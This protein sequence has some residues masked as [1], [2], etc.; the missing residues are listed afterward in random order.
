[1]FNKHANE[2]YS[3]YS[4]KHRNA[5]ECVDYMKE[6]M[7]VPYA[8]FADK[9]FNW[10]HSHSHSFD[11]GSEIH[12][13][14]SYMYYIPVYISCINCELMIC[15]KLR[16]I[17]IRYLKL[18]INEIDQESAHLHAIQAVSKLC[19]HSLQRP[20][21]AKYIFT[22]PTTQLLI[23]QFITDCCTK[24]LILNENVFPLY[25][26]ARQNFFR[27][28]QAL[29]KNSKIWP[30]SWG[31]TLKQ[32]IDK[33]SISIMYPIKIF[34]EYLFE[35]MCKSVFAKG[36][37]DNL[38]VSDE[39]RMKCHLGK[40]LMLYSLI[41]KNELNPFYFHSKWA[42]EDT[43]LVSYFRDDVE[44][45]NKANTGP[46]QMI[47]MLKTHFEFLKSGMKSYH[48]ACQWTQ[49]NVQKKD[50]KDN[51]NCV[52]KKCSR[53]QLARYCTRRCQKMDWNY[54]QHKSI[55]SLNPT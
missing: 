25:G 39:N 31:N 40:S 1:M 13:L 45:I 43:Y 14:R 36:N 35:D 33:F 46:Q 5:T 16:D 34:A 4:P 48:I 52:W 19:Q 21:M 49:C 55:C 15:A 30:N 42:Q 20:H 51:I 27:F 41:F 10:S 23:S 24:L 44:K 22:N 54:G 29:L 47:T 50:T 7:E 26:A 12:N 18:N 38:V 8:G 3:E 9:F 2:V 32:H 37:N 17:L 11:V 6:L 28:M 53:C